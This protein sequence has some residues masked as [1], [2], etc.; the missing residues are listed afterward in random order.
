[1]TIAS[2][3]S[4]S[5]PE[6]GIDPETSRELVALTG[7]MHQ[8]EELLRGVIRGRLPTGDGGR[9]FVAEVA[10][11]TDG[12]TRWTTRVLT[13]VEQ[14]VYSTD[15]R[16]A[17]EPLGQ[18]K[19]ARGRAPL[20]PRVGSSLHA[21]VATPASM[22]PLESAGRAAELDIDLVFIEPDQD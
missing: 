19:R 15:I 1:M 22:H 13:R 2:S 5:W 8:R 21:T 20:D 11:H 16:L 12:E 6:D 10:G 3:I 4:V 7:R 14:R 9:I 17:V 18:A